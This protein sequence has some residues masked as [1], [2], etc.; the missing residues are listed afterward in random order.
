MLSLRRWWHPWAP[1][2]LRSP[3]VMASIFTDVVLATSRVVDE[4]GG[5]VA[6]V[7]PELDHLDRA[8]AGIA[9]VEQLRQR[10]RRG[11]GPRIGVQR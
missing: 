11:R 6:Q 2:A 7:V 10:S 9:D 3:G 4:L 1:R 8:L 5:D